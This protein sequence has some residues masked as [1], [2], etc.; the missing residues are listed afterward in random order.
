M[1]GELSRRLVTRLVTCGIIAAESNDTPNP[2]TASMARP[3][4]FSLKSLLAVIAVLSVP[5]WMVTNSDESVR[6]WGK[7]L[8]GPILCGCAGH[9]AAG[10]GGIW[11]GIAIGAI[12]TAVILL[13]VLP[14]F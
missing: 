2:P 11:P 6:F 13:F 4:Q 5:F 9:L 7:V 1:T 12:L 10:W 3:W 14:L 8:L